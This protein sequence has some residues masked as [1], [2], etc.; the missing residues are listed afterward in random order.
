MFNFDM[1]SWTG[2]E[3]SRNMSENIQWG[4]QRRFQNGKILTKYKNFMGYT[5]KDGELVIVPEEAE[6]VRKIF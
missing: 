4:Y 3:E 1:F 5:C 6:I 2:Q